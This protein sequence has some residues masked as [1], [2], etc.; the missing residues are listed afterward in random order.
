MLIETFNPVYNEIELINKTV[1]LS[2]TTCDQLIDNNNNNNSVSSNDLNSL[3][4]SNN[5][6]FSVPSLLFDLP[7]FKIGISFAVT[8][9]SSMF[10][11]T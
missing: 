10:S 9:V 4:S 1:P 11:L 8:L 2:E 5:L 6:S 7:R 3:N